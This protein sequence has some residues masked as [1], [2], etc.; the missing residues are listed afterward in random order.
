MSKDEEYM[1][2]ALEEAQKAAQKG[3]VPI[4]AIVVDKT[5]AVIGRGHNQKEAHADP[6]LHAEIL[7]IRDATQKLGSWRLSGCHLYVT[8]E[9]CPMCAGALVQSRIEH[10]ILG[11]LDAKG[12][13]VCSQ[14]QVGSNDRLNHQFKVTSGVLEREC[15]LMLKKFFKE[16]RQ[17]KAKPKRVSHSETI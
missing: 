6:T 12:G 16:L 5:G 13:G 4:G 10:L 3:D 2:I 14:F 11:T 9:P 1:K 7:A 15:S 17:Q 8:L